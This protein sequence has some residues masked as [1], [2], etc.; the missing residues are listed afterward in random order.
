MKKNNRQK[1]E[2]ETITR[3]NSLLFSYLINPVILSKQG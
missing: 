2:K 1:I 3:I